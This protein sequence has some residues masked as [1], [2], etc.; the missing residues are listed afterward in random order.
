PTTSTN[1]LYHQSEF[2]LQRARVN[3]QLQLT[4]YFI[5]RFELELTG[6]PALQDAYL[7]SDVFPWLTIRAG[8]FLVPFLQTFQFSEMNISFLDRQIFIPQSNEHPFLSYLTPR[9]IGLSL[10]GLV[11]NT[12]LS[13]SLPVFE[14]ALGMFNGKGPNS[15]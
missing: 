14:Y 12:S 15:T 13:S 10:S 8:Q 9:D 7:E 2:F 5:A 3:V 4:K 6:V 11:G 1:S